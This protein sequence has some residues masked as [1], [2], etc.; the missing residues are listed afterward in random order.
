MLLT[1]QHCREPTTYCLLRHQK[2][3]F[4]KFQQIN[5]TVCKLC[6]D[7]HYSRFLGWC[8]TKKCH[9]FDFFDILSRW[10]PTQPT[11]PT[12]GSICILFQFHFCQRIILSQQTA[13]VDSTPMALCKWAVEL[14][15]FLGPCST[16]ESLPRTWKLS[17]P[18]V[19][20]WRSLKRCETRV[21]NALENISV[22]LLDFS[23]FSSS[24]ELF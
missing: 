23:F 22:Q 2:S 11:M 6:D 16:Q 1:R 20:V 9:I 13:P 19:R 14:L 12:R 5:S 8:P 15:E 7:I 17:I 10:G 18:A 3:K 24:F 4:S 21:A